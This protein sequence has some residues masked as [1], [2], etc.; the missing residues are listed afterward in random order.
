MS[1]SGRTPRS[2]ERPPA[3]AGEPRRIVVTGGAGFIGSAVARL[4]RERGDSV[5]G[6]VRDA[7]PAGR[8]ANLGVELIED[9]LSD[10]A[11]LTEAL[12]GADAVVHAAGRYRIGI[13]REE[14]G[15]MWDANVG[16]TT[17]LF[18]AAEAAAVPRI[19]NVSTVNVFGNTHG[20]IVDETYRRE[21][22]EGFVSWYDESKYR[23][24]EVVEQRIADGAPALI[25]MPG[26]VIGPG[27][28][29]EIGAQLSQAAAGRLRYVAAAGMGISPIHVDDEASGIVAVLDR[30]GIGRSYVLAGDCIRLGEAFAIAAASRAM[31]LPRLRVPDQLLRAMAPFGRLIGQPHLRE[32]VAASVDVTYWATSKRAG[33]ELAFE[34]RSAEAAIRDTFGK[35]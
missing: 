20:R 22:G 14:R 27:D 13:G 15:A 33:E 18:D 29:S 11:R 4:L 26:T 8:I 30:G 9:D 34:P 6:L 16:T 10:V 24:H 21:L 1:A 17:R 12:R 3:A 35:A 5:V 7:R 32:V 23:A 25:A 31:T 2:T 19:V 28:H